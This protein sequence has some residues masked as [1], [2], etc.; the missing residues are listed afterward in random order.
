[1][2]EEP[3]NSVCQSDWGACGIFSDLRKV[4]LKNPKTYARKYGLAIVNILEN[5]LDGAIDHL[6][7]IIEDNP[8]MALIH[9]RI[10]EIFI[11]QS[12]HEKAI[13]YLEKAVELDD[14][15]LT[16]ITWLSLIYH[17]LGKTEEALSKQEA[18]ESHVFSMNV[19][20]Y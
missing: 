2:K 16:S 9:R 14:T 17:R 20:R 3:A 4:L 12:Q 10:A 5:D 6:N 8:Q 11:Y 13:K 19:S 7:A 1:M 18:L 15:D